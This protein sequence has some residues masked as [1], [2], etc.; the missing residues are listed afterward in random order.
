MAFKSIKSYNEARFGN[1]LILR[2]DG[3]YADIIPLYRSIDDVLV[4]DVHYIKSNSYSGYVHCCGANCPAC[5]KGIRVQNKLFM[6]VY[7][8]NEQ[9][10]QFFD[11]SVKF[12]V[13][14]ERDVFT[15]FP[16]PS[17]YVF[18]LTRH[19]AYQDINT[20]Y[21]LSAI[22]RNTVMSFDEIMAK[23]NTRFPDYYNLVCKEYS[24]SELDELINHSTASVTAP[25][26]PMPRT[27]VPTVS[28]SELTKV[29][30]PTVNFDP[31][32]RVDVNVEP[33]NTVAGFSAT[34]DN[35]AIPSEFDYIGSDKD[36]IEPLGDDEVIF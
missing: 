29:D 28:I 14:L 10:I 9:E 27:T 6:P 34:V 12:E 5:R 24:I 33:T 15:K 7:N 22:A 25:Y 26:E 18:R 11:R 31:V 3:A 23:F 19:G 32:P 4:A 1:M 20:T 13:Q 16:N 30:I 36:D 35:K 8:V 21:Q 2:D 17:E